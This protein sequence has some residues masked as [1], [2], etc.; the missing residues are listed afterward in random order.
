MRDPA[1]SPGGVTPRARALGWMASVLVA[2]VL[3]APVPSL[4]QTGVRVVSDINYATHGGIPLLL[5]AYLPPGQGPFPAVVVIP[6]GRWVYI[7]KT[8]HSDVPTYLAEHGIAAFSITYRSALEF[9]YPAAIQDVASAVRWVRS[10]AADYQVDPTDIGAVGDSAGGHLAALVATMGSGPLDTG[11]RVDVVA[12]FS[13]LFDLPPLAHS[14][15]D[16]L[17][18]PVRQFLGCSA[19]ES[20]TDVARRASPITYVDPSDPPMILVNGTADLIPAD[21]P[22]S[23]SEAL[24][25]AGIDNQ[26]FFPQGGHGAGYG[27]G[28]KVLDQVIPYLQAWIAGRPAPVMGAG[29]GQSGDQSG[30][31]GGDQKD[32]GAEVQAPSASPAATSSPEKNVNRGTE[33]S[34]RAVAR[35]GGSSNDVVVVAIAMIAVLVVIGQFL[36]IARLRRQIAAMGSLSQDGGPSS[37]SAEGV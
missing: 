19:T 27:G 36:V 30:T 2:T 9:P 26:V 21:Q 31:D 4:A 25:A 35:A 7:D 22:E 14:S 3:V 15:V 16:D 20:C 1:W 23:M 17:R 8:K 12:S 34:T 10:H 11:A 13:G 6:G 24:D 28:N 33:P 5:D 32:T 18:T 29:N 37:A